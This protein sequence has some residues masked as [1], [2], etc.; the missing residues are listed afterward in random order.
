[1]SVSAILLVETKNN[2]FMA[3][4]PIGRKRTPKLKPAAL[5][6]RHGGSILEQ[7]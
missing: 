6:I 1:M 2:I 7:N 5:T 3:S 4:E